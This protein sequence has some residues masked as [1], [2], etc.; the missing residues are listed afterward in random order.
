MFNEI[1][2]RQKELSNHPLFDRLTDLKSL[3]IFMEQHVFCVL[4]FMSVLKSLQ[5][6]ITPATVPWKPSSYPHLAQRFINE[7]VV[8]EETDENAEGAYKSHFELY[9]DSM[10]EVNAST[11]LMTSFLNNFETSVLTPKLK[12]SCDYHFELSRTGK[13]EETLAAF[14]FGREKLI[15]PMFSTIVSILE[16][17]KLKAPTFLYYLDRHIGLDGDSH[18]PMGMKLFEMLV[19]DEESR[20]RAFKAAITALEHRKNVW[21]ETLELIETSN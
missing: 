10:N 5:N 11:N 15:P 21:D 2:R 7:I 8:G 18:G 16:K 4:D 20:A 3:Q 17:N 12:A 19:T 13:L 1:E 9:L 14:L 6:E